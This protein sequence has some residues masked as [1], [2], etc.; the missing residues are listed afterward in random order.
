MSIDEKYLPLSGAYRWEKEAADDVYM[1]QPMGGGE[2]RTYTWKQ[3]LDEARRMA[4][5]L[6]SLDLPPKSSIGILSKNCAHFIMTDLAIWMAGHVSVAL[7]PTLTADIVKYTLE[8]SECKILFVGKL[9]TWDEMK[10][11]VPEGLPLYSYPLSPPN[12]Y[13]TW[14]D[15]VKQ[16]EP[17]QGNPKREADETSLLIYTSGSTGLPKGVEITFGIQAFTNKGVQETLGIA[18]QDRQLSYLPL[19]HSF[20]RMAVESMSLFG[21]G[22]VFFAESLNTFVQD[23]QRARPTVFISVPRLWL[24]FQLGVF[25]KMPPKKLGRLLKI[26][27]LKGI[28]RK[29][30]LK[31]LGLDCARFAVSGSAPIPADLIVWY[32]NLGLELLEGYGMTENFAYS[33]VNMPGRTR[34]GY[35]GSC[36]PGVEHKIG[37]NDEVLIKSNATMKG[38]FKNPEATAEA[39]DSDGFL[40]TG[41]RGEIDEQ[42]RLKITGRVK[43]LF[44][45]SK[46]KYVA[47]VPIENLLNSSNYIEQSCVSGSGQPMAYAIVLLSEDIRAKIGDKAV[48]NEVTAAMTKL[49]GEVNAE[50]A[51]HEHLQFIAVAKDEWLIENGFLTPTMKIKRSVLEDTYDPKLEAWYGSKEKVIWEE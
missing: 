29:K 11:G 1:T 6:Q 33:H 7:Y 31:G 17:L 20:E 19:A 3:T 36:F 2:V 5:F 8:H 23:L 14:D 15:L 25:K 49:L 24:K 44:K 35:V 42:G 22:Q 16:H 13:P 38:Y 41:D 18:R 32:R 46:G 45:T 47:P 9:D 21:G 26:P 40:H 12:D 30:I 50:L 28:V 43:E 4:T 34:A 37:E 48:R 27:I 39:I 10:P 51:H